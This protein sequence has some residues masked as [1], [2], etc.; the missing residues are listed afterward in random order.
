VLSDEKLADVR[1]DFSASII[2]RKRQLAE[3]TVRNWCE[4]NGLKNAIVRYI[5]EGGGWTSFSVFS[6]Y[7]QDQ[8]FLTLINN[9]TK[10]AFSELL[11][12]LRKIDRRIRIQT[13]WRSL[14]KYIQLEAV[15]AE[16]RSKVTQNETALNCEED[17]MNRESEVH[18]T[19][20]FD[21]E[22]EILLKGNMEEIKK[23]FKK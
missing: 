10:L 9:N 13:H 17:S 11:E 18:E 5:A 6:S 12:N 16:W 21:A 19:E 3:Q 8:S 4:A 15:M 20:D 1:Y 7:L 22:E 14:E 2:T 23:H